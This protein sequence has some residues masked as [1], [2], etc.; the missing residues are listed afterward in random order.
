MT[1]S[2]DNGMPELAP[3]LVKAGYPPDATIREARLHLCKDC[4]APFAEFMKNEG[5]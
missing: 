2:S 1:L 4:L 5:G 3:L